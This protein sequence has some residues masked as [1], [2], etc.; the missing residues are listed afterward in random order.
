MG[1]MRSWAWSQSCDVSMSDK[2]DLI[3]LY[4]LQRPWGQKLFG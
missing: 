1:T 2:L 4:A 3:R